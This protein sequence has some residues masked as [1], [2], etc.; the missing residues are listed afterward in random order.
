MPV[1]LKYHQPGE[2]PG[3]VSPIDEAIDQMVRG[4]QVDIACPYLGLAYLKRVIKLASSW[5]LLTDVDQW[6]ISQAQNSRRKIYDFITPHSERVRHYPDLHAK[7]I[8]AQEK[9]LVGSANF[10][11]KGIAGRIEMCALFEKTSEVAELRDWFDRLWP[12][13][14]LVNSDQLLSTLIPNAPNA[15]ILARRYRLSSRAPRI[16]S[17]L[18]SSTKEPA[19]RIARNSRKATNRLVQPAVDVDYPNSVSERTVRSMETDKRRSAAVKAAID[20]VRSS[21]YVEGIRAAAEI[22]GAGR[23]KGFS[24]EQVR[25]LIK[26][27]DLDNYGGGGYYGKYKFLR[28]ELER[29][30][31]PENR[32]K[33]GREIGWRKFRDG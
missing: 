5:R 31:I 21:E 30:A 17:K 2:P 22:I 32:K 24:H 12:L 27:G 25:N 1:T 10:T 33:P 19:A 9:A 16:N 6:I 4:Q 29:L 26:A 23:G 8:I 13:S 11:L 18:A 3:T 7:V 20:A 14:D 15:T 28:S